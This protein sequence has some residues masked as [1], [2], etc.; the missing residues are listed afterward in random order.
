MTFILLTHKAHEND[1]VCVMRKII[2]RKTPRNKEMC[3]H[4]AKKKTGLKIIMKSQ[5]INSLNKFLV[6]C[7]LKHENTANIQVAKKLG[8][9]MGKKIIMQLKNNNN[10]VIQVYCLFGDIMYNMYDNIKIAK[11]IKRHKNVKKYLFPLP[12]FIHVMSM[13]FI[14]IIRS[15]ISL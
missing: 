2:I 5:H 15:L 11:R 1:I 10:K 12:N 14:L 8:M 6:E 9:M 3:H 7:F 13:L 4:K